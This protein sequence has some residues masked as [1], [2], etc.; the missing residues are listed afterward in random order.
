M[1]CRKRL[2]YGYGGDFRILQKKINDLIVSMPEQ[3]KFCADKL[4]GR[5]FNQTSVLYQQDERYAGHYQ[6]FLYKKYCR[7]HLTAFYCF[8]KYTLD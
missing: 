6:L 1:G 3:N 2:F 8:F 5:G 4:H 7:S